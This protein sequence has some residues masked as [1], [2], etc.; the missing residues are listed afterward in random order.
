[1]SNKKTNG[2]ILLNNIFSLI[3]GTLIVVITILLCPI[4]IVLWLR[5]EPVN[6]EV[7]QKWYAWRPVELRQSGKYAWFKWVEKY[8]VCHYYDDHSYVTRTYREQQ[9]ENNNG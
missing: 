9:K 6:Y 5:S 1:M 3:R 4:G 8:E 2:G 7:W